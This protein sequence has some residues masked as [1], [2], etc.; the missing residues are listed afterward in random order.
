[1]KTLSLEK[2]F[3]STKAY[4]K[5]FDGLLH[6]EKKETKKNISELLKDLGINDSTYRREIYP[7]QNSV[8]SLTG[9]K[10]VSFSIRNN[11]SLDKEGHLILI[12]ILNTIVM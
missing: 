7:L 12:K 3:I 8:T 9:K 2:Y 4:Y 10:S 6:K 11:T 5:F 1:M